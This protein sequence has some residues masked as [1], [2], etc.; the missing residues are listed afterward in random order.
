MLKISGRPSVV[1]ASSTASM[2]Q[3]RSR[4]VDTRHA[5]TF[6]L[7]QSITA[8]RETKPRAIGMA[9]AALARPGL[10]DEAR[11]PHHGISKCTASI[12]RINAKSASATDRG[13]E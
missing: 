13:A 3:V 6:R 7:A 10:R 1:I 4:V 11:Q 8:A 9:A 2:Q 12:R 5:R